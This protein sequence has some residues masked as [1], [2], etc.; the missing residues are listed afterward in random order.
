MCVLFMFDFADDT[1]NFFG[2][3]LFSFITDSFEHLSLMPH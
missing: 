3:N 1:S 2:D